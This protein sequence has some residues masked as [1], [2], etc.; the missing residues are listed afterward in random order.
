MAAKPWFAIRDGSDPVPRVSDATVLNTKIPSR[1][2][3]VMISEWRQA[4]PRDLS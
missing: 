1:V 2:K 3:P 4:L